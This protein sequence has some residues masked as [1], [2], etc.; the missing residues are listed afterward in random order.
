MGNEQRGGV[1]IGFPKYIFCSPFLADLDKAQK[2]R[3]RGRWDFAH[4]GVEAEW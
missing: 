4:S 2:P 3:A 1:E